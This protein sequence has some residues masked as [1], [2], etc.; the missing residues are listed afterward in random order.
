MRSLTLKL[1]L[2]FLL[3]ALIG[4]ILVAGFVG[5]R[6]QAEFNRFVLNRFQADLVATLADTY[7]RNGSWQ[8]IAAMVA[9]NAQIRRRIP[10]GAAAP[11]LLTD[12]RGEILIG[13]S[14]HPVGDH[15]SARDR[16]RAVPISVDGKTV[17]RVLFT[18]G[19]WM[20]RLP[21]S[22][23]LQFLKQVRRAT[24]L[25]ALGATLI[26][27][28]L[29]AL[30]AY[31]ITRPLR[32]LKTGTHMIAKGKLGYQV[33]VH[34]KDEIGDLANSFNRM[35]S[36]LA[37]ASKMRRQ[38]TADIAHDLRTPLSV[39]LGYA[40]ALNDGKL[41]GNAETYSILHSEALHLQHLIEDLR[42][43]SLADAG[44]LSLDMQPTDIQALLQRI[45]AAYHAAA[46]ERDIALQIDAAA[47]PI[48]RMDPERMM[49]VL[50]NLVS[51]ALRYTP[52][53]GVIRLTAESDANSLILRLQDTGAGIPPE[54]LPYV[55]ERFYRADPSRHIGEGESGLGLAIAKSLVELQGGSISVRSQLGQGTIFEIRFPYSKSANGV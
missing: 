49:Q 9:H 4:T 32:D 12:A 30:L 40:E 13:N 20:V 41:S 39:I 2:A 11:F 48:V 51:N 46:S 18:D 44:E 38:M 6:I 37:R 29:G 7:E 23:E 27:V 5:A 21:Q 34:T 26:A 36:E 28:M 25:A 43:L 54:S 52:A 55:F 24:V 10:R 15:L 8:N 3:V 35:S 45:A 50:G 16:A 31:T 42:T 22:L 53:G 17:G 1:T 19:A 47:L 33:Q 14:L